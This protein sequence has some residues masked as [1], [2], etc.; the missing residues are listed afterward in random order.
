MDICEW[1]KINCNMKIGKFQA[2]GE[3]GKHVRIKIWGRYYG[4]KSN[5]KRCKTI[6]DF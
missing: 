3:S 5:N 1:I 4:K 2:S 6:R